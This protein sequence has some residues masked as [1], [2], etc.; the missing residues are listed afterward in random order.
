MKPSIL[1]VEDD[2]N[3]GFIICDELKIQGYDVKLCM[4]GVEAMQ[5]FHNRVYH[6]C[7]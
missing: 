5:E 4:D 6:L 3:L 1:L 2:I 7:V